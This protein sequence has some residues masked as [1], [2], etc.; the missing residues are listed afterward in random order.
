MQ[1]E[2]D[3]FGVFVFAGYQ[4]NTSLVKDIVELNESGYIVTDQNQ[5]TNKEGIYGAGDVCIKEL[6]QVVT[7]VSDGA[8]AAT[9][10]EKYVEKMHQKT[11]I[12]PKIPQVKK[13]EQVTVNNDSLLDEHM[14]SQLQAVFSRMEIQLFLNYYSMKVRYPMN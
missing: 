8:K 5:K 14:L 9:S 1:N 10:L 12:I 7:A 6:R 4:P 13:E 3:T 11:G 2:N